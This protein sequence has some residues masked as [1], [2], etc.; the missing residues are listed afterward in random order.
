MTGPIE[1]VYA[2]LV[3]AG[4]VML[5]AEIYLPGGVLGVLGAL[6]LVAAVVT[7]FFIGTSFGFLSAAAIVILSAA[8]LYLFVRVFPKTGAGRRLTLTASG[9][10][11]ISTPEGLESLQ[12]REGIAESTL[13]PSGIAVVDNRRIDVVARGIWIEAGT[14]IRVAAIHGNR[15]EVVPAV[16]P[17]A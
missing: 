2:G 1:T 9:S 14:R 11:F 8:G 17:R 13:R 5:G 6:S 15:I 3:V 12:D 16:E 4:I 7:G 10:D